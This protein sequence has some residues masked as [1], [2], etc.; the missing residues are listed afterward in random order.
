MNGIMQ[1]ELHL[2][3]RWSSIVAADWS[4]PQYPRLVMSWTSVS[5]SQSGWSMG[6]SAYELP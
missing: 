3:M 6:G 5:R 4:K 2:E 1:S